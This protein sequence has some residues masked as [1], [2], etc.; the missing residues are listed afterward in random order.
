MPVRRGDVVT[1]I[2]WY[3]REFLRPAWISRFLTAKTEPLVTPPYFR[4]FPV[5]TENECTQCLACM[6]ICPAPEAIV[7]VKRGGIWRPEITKGH[8]IRCGL[9]VE[10]C[11]EDVLASGQILA[12]K[13]EEKLLISGTYHISINPK[14]CMGCGNCSVV[15]PV[16]REIDPSLRSSGTS[17]SNEVIMRVDTGQTKV[18]HEEKCTGCKTCEEH[19]PNNAIRV[20][21]VVEATE[22]EEV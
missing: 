4:D 1:S 20:A 14:T 12:I 6:M 21:R 13:K 9:C 3:I 8:C 11:P 5:T 16:N 18:F 2:I 15:C 7:V 10:A 22:G 17:R 19:C